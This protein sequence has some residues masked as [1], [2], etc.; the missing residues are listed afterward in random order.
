MKLTKTKLSLESHLLISFHPLDSK[1]IYQQ[2]P[3]VFSLFVSSMIIS[4]S[5]QNITIWFHKSKNMLQYSQLKKPM[6]SQLKK[7]MYSQLKKHVTVL[8]CYKRK[9]EILSTQ[10]Q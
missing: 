2:S 4:Y 6:Y 5:E 3:S 8:Q 10:T 9:L 1:I 7:P